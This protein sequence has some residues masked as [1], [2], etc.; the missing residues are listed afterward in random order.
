MLSFISF[1]SVNGAKINE[2]LKN[3]QVGEEISVKLL[4]K[5]SKEDQMLVSVL[6]F[7]ADSV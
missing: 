1:N 4:G 5:V 7:Q 2:K 3:L 6:A